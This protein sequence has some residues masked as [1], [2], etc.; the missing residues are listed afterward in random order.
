MYSTPPFAADA[1]P[2]T[3]GVFLAGQAHRMLLYAALDAAG[4]ALQIGDVRAVFDI[5]ELDH[6]TVQT[7]VTWIAV[8]GRPVDG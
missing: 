4:V 6:V 3:A 1:S 5:A 2:R 8:A 7:V